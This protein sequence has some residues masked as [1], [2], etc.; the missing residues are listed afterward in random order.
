[1]GERITPEQAATML[2]YSLGHVYRLL[3][4]GRLPGTKW[5]PDSAKGTWELDREQVEEI[6]KKQDLSGRVRRA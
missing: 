2:G 5:P 1:M 6:K 3:E 4:Q